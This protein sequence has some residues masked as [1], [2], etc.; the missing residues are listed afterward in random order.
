M[1]RPERRRALGGYI[2]DLLLNGERKSIEFMAARLAERPGQT[3]ALRQRLQHCFS[4]VAW[5]VASGR[6]AAG[7][8]PGAPP[9]RVSLGHVTSM[10]QAIASCPSS[11]TGRPIGSLAGYPLGLRL[12]SHRGPACSGASRVGY[13]ET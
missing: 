4:S 10:S 9:N 12:R 7:A 6:Q 5:D 13:A 2:S 8:S 11:V 1:G 3:E